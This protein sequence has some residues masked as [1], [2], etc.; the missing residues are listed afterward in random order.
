MLIYFVLE[1]LHEIFFLKSAFCPHE[2]HFRSP[3]ST[4]PP[5]LTYMD[6]PIIHN[7]R[8]FTSAR[9][10]EPHRESWLCIPVKWP[11]GLLHAQWTIGRVEEHYAS[12][13]TRGNISGRWQYAHLWLTY[14]P[15]WWISWSFG[16]GKKTTKKVDIFIQMRN[17]ARVREE[18]PVWEIVTHH[19]IFAW[20]PYPCSLSKN[21][22]RRN[23]LVIP[24]KALVFGT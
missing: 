7:K 4:S 9:Q 18:Y 16:S 10:A 20:C 13:R 15:R 14:T 8:S 12:Q 5:Y 3:G 6:E 2:G 23:R 17:R 19:D 1:I 11:D 21:Q 22:K 24:C